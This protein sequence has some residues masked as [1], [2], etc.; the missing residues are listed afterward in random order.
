MTTGSLVRRLGVCVAAVGTAVMLIATPGAASAASP[1]RA[2]SAT[3]TGPTATAGTVTLTP[4][5]GKGVR[6]RTTFTCSISYPYVTDNFSNGN[7]AWSAAN[8]CSTVLRMQGT[9]V[10]YQWGSTN[11]YAFGS[12]YDNYSTYNSSS[13]SV[14]GIYSGNWGVNNNVLLFIPAGYTTT[15]GGGCYYANSSEIQCTATS[16]PFTAQ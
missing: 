1:S 2:G 15:V 9:T 3:F 6:P 14:Y 10:L 16:G 11:A 7:I 13:G 8:S 5:A 12:S 4:V